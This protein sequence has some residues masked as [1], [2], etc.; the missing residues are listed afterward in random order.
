MK[1][2]LLFIAML[3]TAFNFANAQCDPLASIDDDFES[4][5]AG[6]GEPMP[7]CWT[8]KSNDG[9]HIIGMRDSG[10]EANSG[11]KYV[12]AY[13]FF[14]FNSTIYFISPELTTIDGSNQANFFI[15]ASEGNVKMQTGIMSDADARNTFAPIGEDVTLGTSYAQYETG[16]IAGNDS[17]KYFAI[18]LTVPNWH[19][20]V[21]MDDFK[22][23]MV[24]TQNCAAP[25][26]V[27]A[28]EITTTAADLE[29]DEVAG[30]ESYVLEYGATGF[31]LG[32]GT[33]VTASEE[34]YDLSGL[35]ASTAYDV[36]VQAV[37]A[38]ASSEFSSVYTFTTMVEAATC[39]TPTNVTDDKITTTSVELEWDEV[40]GAQS[41]VIEYGATGFTLGNGTQVTSNEEE[42]DLSGLS[43]STNYDIYVQ[44][45][46]TD[47][48]S[49]FSSAFTFTTDDEATC[50]IPTN[51][52]ADDIENNS[53]ELEWD[54]VDGAQSYVIEYGATGFTLGSGT[55]VTSDEED[56]ELE[57]LSASTSY[58]VYV[59]AICSNGAESEFSAVYTFSTVVSSTFSNALQAAIK[60]LGNPVQNDCIKLQKSVD[61][62][63]ILSIINVA[64]QRLYTSHWTDNTIAIDTEN[65]QKGIYFVHLNKADQFLTKKI[66]IE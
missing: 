38:E 4:Y 28:D 42:Y 23:E 21:R 53:V 34:E 16:A 66:I 12:S 49:D 9:Q 26:N 57:N 39:N 33:Q 7:T 60:V 5:A 61:D 6:S 31:T 64:G 37:C 56:Y 52:E 43:A 54:E 35:T 17:S 19:T 48:S 13:T 8:K 50:D 40:D 55:Q 20:V 47:V 59:K 58:D 44:A 46:C 32:S 29:W 14:A 18:K 62:E 11:T 41:Y 15:K 25:Q 1:T 24:A 22:W 27:S 63:M 10:G 2:Y 36:Y 51:I 30:A 45:V 65:W 3:I